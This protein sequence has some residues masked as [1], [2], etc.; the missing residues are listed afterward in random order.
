MRLRLPAQ[1]N[2]NV[3]ISEPNTNEKKKFQ[4]L[5]RAIEEMQESFAQQEREVRAF[6][7]AVRALQE[8]ISATSRHLRTYNDNLG[9]IDV[10]RLGRKAR[11]LSDMMASY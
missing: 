1:T 6:Q 5:S 2:L 10:A 8:G 7:Q 3:Q 4:R 11:Q 9:R